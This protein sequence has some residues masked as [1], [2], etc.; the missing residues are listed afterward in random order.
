MKIARVVMETEMQKKKKK[1]G[2]HEWVN[3]LQVTSEERWSAVVSFMVAS[4][5]M[6]L[7]D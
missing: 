5:E 7:S 3:S 1:F 2:N 6:A 4:W